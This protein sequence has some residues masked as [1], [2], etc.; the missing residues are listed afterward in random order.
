VQYAPH[1]VPG[2]ALSVLLFR[3]PTDSSLGQHLR[4]QLR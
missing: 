1:Q 2:N 4:A 3:A